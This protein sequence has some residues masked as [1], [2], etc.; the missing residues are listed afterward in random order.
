MRVLQEELGWKYYGGKH[1]E[2]IY[3]R[4]F[5][6]YILPHKFGIDKR[7]AHF[8]T[9]IC[10]GQMSREQALEEL[11]TETYPEGLQKDDYQ[12]VIKKFNLSGDE[13]ER[14]MTLPVKDFLQY[15]NEH[16]MMQSL[17]KVLHFL[18]Q[19]GMLKGNTSL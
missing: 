1:Y 6:G 5:Q 17:R 10:S 3:T 7:L 8:S 15:P 19:H 2:S 14:I 4:F 16:Q 18:Q 9:L 11:K 13:F 12:Y